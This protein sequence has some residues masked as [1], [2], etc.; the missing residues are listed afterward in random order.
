MEDRGQK[1]LKVLIRI[2]DYF[3]EAIDKFS[4]TVD[5]ATKTLTS[6]LKR[7][8]K[9]LKSIEI[10]SLPAS[11]KST[12]TAV[13][14]TV[15]AKRGEI[16]STEDL[17]AALTGRVAVSPEAAVEQ[18]AEASTVSTV[19]PAVPPEKQTLGTPPTMPSVP[20]APPSDSGFEPEVTI[21]SAVRPPQPGEAV[22]TPP[23]FAVAMPSAV[24]GSS[25]TDL[26]QPSVGS[27][28]SEMLKELKR[29]KKL[30]TGIT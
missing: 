18:Q 22:A 23:Q 25:E 26:E 28:K 9:D 27:L 15:L 4:K 7:I 17:W 24:P 10:G 2:K 12:S 8:E 3:L 6:S 20:S 19:I 16:M 29:L 1:T 21:P 13:I 14:T 11:E 5:E 30:M